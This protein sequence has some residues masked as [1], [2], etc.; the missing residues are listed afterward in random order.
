MFGSFSNHSTKNN[1]NLLKRSVILEKK[2]EYLTYGNDFLD[3]K[4]LEYNLDGNIKKSVIKDFDSGQLHD[5]KFKFHYIIT[6]V[7]LLIISFLLL[8]GIHQFLV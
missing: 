3:G 4:N 7:V 8:L 5:K 1:L 2:K 6:I